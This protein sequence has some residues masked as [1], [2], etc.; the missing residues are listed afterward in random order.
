MTPGTRLGP[1]E[2]VAPLGASGMG[3]VYRAR[4]TRLDR[5]GAIKILPTDFAQ[6]AQFKMGFEREAKT[7]SQSITRTGRGDSEK[8]VMSGITTNSH[9]W[10]RRR[11]R[12]GDGS[13][14]DAGC[15]ST[16]GRQRKLATR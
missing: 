3:E 8:Y 9:K 16:S 13:G 15:G 2:I 10:R 14:E 12:R 4:D 1:Y 11:A 7:I 6:N 5:S